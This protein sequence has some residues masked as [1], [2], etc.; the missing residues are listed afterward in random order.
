MTQ[1][2][3]RGGRTYI[4]GMHG[5]H[6][7]AMRQRHICFIICTLSNAGLYL[8]F[9]VLLSTPVCFLEFP[10]HS[11]VYKQGLDHKLVV[12]VIQTSSST[13]L[14]LYLLFYPNMPLSHPTP[15]PPSLYTFILT[16]NYNLFHMLLHLCS[17]AYH[18]A[19]SQQKV[20][21]IFHFS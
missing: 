18:P 13:S 15:S 20:L 4:R 21:Y 1:T 5:M 19:A 3:W 11:P 16:I 6:D 7:S 8:H 12:P 10:F 17:L 2:N 14:L 9:F